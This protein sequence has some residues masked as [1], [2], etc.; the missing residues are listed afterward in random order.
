MG[1]GEKETGCG[2]SFPLVQRASHKTRE[3]RT[4]D[5]R[6]RGRSIEGERYP[7]KMRQRSLRSGGLWVVQRRDGKGGG[8]GGGGGAGGSSCVKNRNGLYKL[9]E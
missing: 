5:L 3:G 2:S 6:R 4:G 7:S 1:R 8:G 9:H